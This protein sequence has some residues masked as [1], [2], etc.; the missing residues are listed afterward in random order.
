MGGELIRF[1]AKT[2]NP[3]LIL[4]NALKLSRIIQERGVSLVHARSRAPA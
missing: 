3:G 2:K 4:L 1:P